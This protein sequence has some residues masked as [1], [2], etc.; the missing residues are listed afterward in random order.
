MISELLV[1]GQKPLMGLDTAPV[2][3]WRGDFDFTQ[4]AYRLQIAA[5]APVFDSG[6]VESGES[7]WISAAFPMQSRTAYTWSVSLR[8]TVGIEHALGS[9]SFETGLLGQIDWIAAWIGAGKAYKPNWA[10]YYRREFTVNGTVKRARL[11][12]SGLG[13]GVPR[14]NGQR[15]GDFKLDPAQTEYTEKVFYSVYDVTDLLVSGVNCFGTELGDGWYSQNQLM[16]GDGVYGPPCLRAQLMIDYTDGRTDVIGTDKSF[17]CTLSPTCYNNLYIGETFDG[18]LALSGWDQPGFDDSSWAN[19]VWDTVKKGRMAWQYLPPM[20]VTR[21]I[22]PVNVTRPI[23]GVA[24]MDFGENLAGTVRLALRGMPGNAVRIRFAEALDETGNLAP[25]SS[26]VF[27]FRGVQTLTY[28]FGPET[29]P[30][31][32]MIQNGEFVYTGGVPIVWEPEFC[33]FGF[34]YAEITGAHVLPDETTL[35]ALKIHTDFPE[36]TSFSCDEPI[37]NTMETLLKRTFPNNAQGLPTD[38]PA[39]EKCGWTGDAN[40]I[41]E[42]ALLMWNCRSFFE[43]FTEDIADCRQANGVYYNV[44]PG[45]R[46]CLDTVPAWGSAIIHIPWEIYSFGGDKT[47]LARQYPAM[48]AYGR[49]LLEHSENGVYENH[50]YKL[51]DWAAPYGYRS[52]EHFFEISAI[53]L[54]LSFTILGKSAEELK[55][56]DAA[57]WF[58]EAEKVK[59]TLHTKYYHFDAHTYGSQTLNAFADFWGLIPAGEENAAADWTEQDVIAH[60]DHVTCGHIGLRYVYQYLHKYGRTETL[61]RVL[62]SR[63]YPSFGAQL[64]A[65]ATTL[66]ETAETDVNCHSLDHPFRGGYCVWLYEDLLGVK[67]LLPGFRRFAVKPVPGIVKTAA[68][69]VDTPYGRISVDYTVGDRLR[70]TVPWNTV[71]EV[72][73]PNSTEVHV[74]TSGEYVL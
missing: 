13:I 52:E 28:I 29:A 54:Y 60:D 34:R 23:P 1:N 8:D 70:V 42:A 45:K 48:A 69:H 35:T 40:V 50:Q 38:C 26:G 65:G 19:A 9:S 62:N 39:R 53:Y 27:H 25:A 57:F 32:C 64:D 43:K 61:K 6:W 37:L 14:L 36:S 72:T 73:L 20:R 71:A 5:E 18:R 44:V 74:L 17:K 30:G 47:L 51:A 22:K 41:S 49:Y 7:Q 46:H 31:G 63:T 24:I 3:S 15:V 21:E 4:A 16:E 11:Y 56:P 59:K 2:F 12:F 66:W 58:G 10:M 68:G 67:P 55:D 33:Y